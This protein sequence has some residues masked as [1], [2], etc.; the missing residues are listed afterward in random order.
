M[1]AMTWQA[2]ER[3][4]QAPFRRPKLRLLTGGA[5]AGPRDE[6]A[7]SRDALARSRHEVAGARDAPAR[8]RHE[9]VGARDEI[10]RSGHEVAGARNAVARSRAAVAGAR[11]AA[12]VRRPLPVQPAWE[13]TRRGMALALAALGTLL[14]GGVG[15]LVWGFLQVSDAPIL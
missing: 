7:R 15:T 3:T 12:N 14:A 4:R 5:A 9:V 13:L 8:S 2:E 11:D 1:T 6:I 10:A